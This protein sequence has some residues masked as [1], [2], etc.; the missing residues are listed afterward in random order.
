M[1]IDYY[2]RHFNCKRKNFSLIMSRYWRLVTN[3]LKVHKVLIKL[4]IYMQLILAGE[5]QYN[6]IMK[7]Y[8]SNFQ[9]HQKNNSKLSPLT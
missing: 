1:L 9:K 2:N 8:Q 4:A 3:L 7:D 6:Y 5:N